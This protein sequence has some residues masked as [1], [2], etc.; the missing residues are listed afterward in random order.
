MKVKRGREYMAN[1]NMFSVPVITFSHVRKDMGK[2][3]L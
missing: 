2:W 3:I 1:G